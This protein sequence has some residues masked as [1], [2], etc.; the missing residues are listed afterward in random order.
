[1]HAQVAF[2]GTGTCAKWTTLFATPEGVFDY[3]MFNW[4][5][6]KLCCPTNS[7]ECRTAARLCAANRPAVTTQRT[8]LGLR[9]L[10]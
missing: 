7:G 1:M 5:N 3:A 6:G 10:C 4:G 8:P 2:V 9:S